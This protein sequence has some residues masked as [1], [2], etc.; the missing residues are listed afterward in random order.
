M[1]HLMHNGGPISK[2]A[3]YT[4]LA[5]ESGTAFVS[6]A[7]D[8]VFTLPAAEKGLWYTFV[9][10]IVSVTTG[11]SISPVAADS[12][13]SG[14]VNKDLINTPATDVL[15]DSVTVASDGTDW[16]TVEMHGIWAAEA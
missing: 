12:I 8:V 16:W 14:V 10:G 11:L 15:G 7:V 3:A 4:V 1:K 2:G 13:N 5:S 6:T 9:A